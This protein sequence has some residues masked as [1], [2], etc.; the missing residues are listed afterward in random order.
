MFEDMDFVWLVLSMAGLLLIAMQVF[1]DW[2]KERAKDSKALL[3]EAERQTI[4][5]RNIEMV[6]RACTPWSEREK[7]AS[8]YHMDTELMCVGLGPGLAPEGDL[9][10][11]E[12]RGK[13]WKELDTFDPYNKNE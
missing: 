7:L 8:G 11:R 4:L 13:L 3:H 12:A 2:E 1:R 5:L 6:G 9:E 10:L